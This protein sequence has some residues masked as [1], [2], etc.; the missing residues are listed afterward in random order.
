MVAVA[1]ILVG[2]LKGLQG[3]SENVEDTKIE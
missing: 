3:A 1:G 2:I